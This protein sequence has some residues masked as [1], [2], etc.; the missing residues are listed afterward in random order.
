MHVRSILLLAFGL[1]ALIGCGKDSS[2]P[3]FADL[4]PVK[5]VV[6]RGGVPVKKGAVR[7]TPDP[8]KQEFT[9]NSEVGEDGTFSLTTVRITDKAGERRPGAPAGKYKV[10]FVPH[11]GDQTAGGFT[12]PV[13]LPQVVTVEA[14]ENDLKLELPKKK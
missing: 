1:A 8:D 9:I 3:A 13:E 6:T 2:Q 4:Y 10:T 7:F 12:D 14:K 11:L 5:G